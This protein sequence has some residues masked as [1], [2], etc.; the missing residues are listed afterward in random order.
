MAVTL[1]GK[2]YDEA[3][4]LGYSYL[5]KFPSPIFSDMLEELRKANTIQLLSPGAAG[6]YARSDGTNWVRVDDLLP[7]TNN[8]RDLG[9]SALRWRKAW[10]VDADISG[11]VSNRLTAR[12]G[13]TVRDGDAVSTGSVVFAD[14][15]VVIRR[16]ALGATSG[17]G[18]A[19]Q[20][21]GYD[22]IIF[23]ESNHVFASM[24]ERMRLRNGN[25]LLGTTTDAGYRFDVA[26]GK[27]RLT[28]GATNQDSLSVEGPGGANG[29]WIG[30]KHFGHQWRSVVEDGGGGGYGLELWCSGG[31]NGGGTTKELHVTYQKH[32]NI[33]GP[34]A[35]DYNGNGKLNVKGHLQST[36][37]GGGLICKTPD[38]LKFYLI[39]VT[40]TGAIE[41]VL[42]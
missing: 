41:S 1:N 5:T 35:A 11:G 18:N 12:D 3:D 9:S 25:L 32:F 19:L 6:G 21:G 38:G 40:N 22:G 27:T 14:E 2:T 36:V 4:F 17:A 34:A 16:A 23:R 37:A 8:A 39:R 15:N 29:S 10:L 26:G 28:T 33:G 7:G 24:V 20:L 31:G 13:V 30:L 42:I